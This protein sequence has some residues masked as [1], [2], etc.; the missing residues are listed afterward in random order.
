MKKIKRK[1][2]NAQ[3][4]PWIMFRRLNNGYPTTGIQQPHL[5]CRNYEDI[6][7]Q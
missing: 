3:H 7:F 1:H 2:V 5:K 4:T 6:F